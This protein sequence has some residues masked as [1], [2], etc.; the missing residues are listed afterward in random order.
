MS[1]YLKIEK[2][3]VKLQKEIQQN[4]AEIATYLFV[5]FKSLKI[6]NTLKKNKLP[7]FCYFYLFL[8]VF[9]RFIKNGSDLKINFIDHF[10]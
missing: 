10:F 7:I 4:K 5:F 9:K 3:K 6:I 8:S 2:I 1:I